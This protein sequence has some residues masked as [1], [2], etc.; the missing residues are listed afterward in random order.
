MLPQG[1]EL[2]LVVIS[3]LLQRGFVAAAAHR[4]S[5]VRRTRG[6]VRK[7]MVPALVRYV[8]LYWC[9]SYNRGALYIHFKKL[10]AQPVSARGANEQE[11]VEG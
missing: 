3:T 8:D 9:G 10:T 2:L 7:A 11:D 6:A 5:V 1:L 4:C